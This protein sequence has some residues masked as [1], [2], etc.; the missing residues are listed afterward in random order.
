M[1]RRK[2]MKD[3]NNNISKL[4]DLAGKKPAIATLYNVIRFD[5]SRY[6]PIRTEDKKQCHACQSYSCVT[7]KKYKILLYLKDSQ[8]CLKT[9][10]Y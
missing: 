2:V 5:Q 6:W 10:H 3:V 9:F 8:N 7:C 1:T 4:L